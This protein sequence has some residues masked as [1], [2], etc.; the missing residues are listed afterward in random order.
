MTRHKL[1]LAAVSATLAL[2]SPLFGQDKSK[3]LDRLF[4]KGA[5]VD[6]MEEIKLS[7]AAQ[8]QAQSEDVKRFAQMLVQ[9]HQKSDQQLKQLA[10]SKGVD[11]PSDLPEMKKEKVD[12][13]SSLQ[14][15]EFDK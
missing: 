12:A 14:G 15:S 6:N 5:A 8:Q 7:Q 2:G 3:D 13:I 4:L 10:Q 11:I 9:D 1:L